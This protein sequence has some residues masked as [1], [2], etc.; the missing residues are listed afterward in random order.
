MEKSLMFKMKEAFN[1]KRILI[2]GAG[3]IGCELVKSIRGLPLEEIHIID[4]D[5]IEISNLNRQ[6]Y[7]RQ[8]DIGKYKAE[9]LAKKC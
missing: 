7:F 8:K 1:G 9:I 2:V 5:A 3:G 4:M 6:F